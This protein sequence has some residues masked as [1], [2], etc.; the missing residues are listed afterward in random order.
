MGI[1]SASNTAVLQAAETQNRLREVVGEDIRANFI[2]LPTEALVDGQNVEVPV[3][4]NTNPSDNDL[5]NW[6]LTSIIR[7]YLIKGGL[8]ICSRYALVTFPAGAENITYQPSWGFGVGPVL[9]VENSPAQELESQEEQEREAEAQTAQTIE[10]TTSVI[11]GVLGFLALALCGTFFFVKYARRKSQSIQ[12]STLNEDVEGI[13][14]TD[15][16]IISGN[17]SA[18]QSLP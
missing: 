7:P 4:I 15:K 3:A 11:G 17:P 13:P 1:L 18:Y 5:G 12:R 9:P 16:I 2:D 14:A 6:K 10:I 8:S